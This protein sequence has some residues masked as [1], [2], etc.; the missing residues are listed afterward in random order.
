MTVAV[1]T[2]SSASSLATNPLRVH[3]VA[4]PAVG[5]AAA[6]LNPPFLATAF[7]NI[8]AGAAG[9]G[10]VERQGYLFAIYLP[11]ARVGAQ[12]PGVGEAAAGGTAAAGTALATWN[13]AD[14]ELYWCAYAWPVEAGKTGNRAFFINQEGDVASTSNLATAA[15]RY[16]GNA[17]AANIL[18]FGAAFSN[19]VAN[20]MDQ[21]I[22]FASMGF[23]SNDTNLWTQ[24]GN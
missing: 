24:V 7:G 9:P 10:V 20:S 17:A 8:A 22:G 21:P 3:T 6:L 23:T 19:T 13:T 16:T 2:A 14:C 4:N 1:S 11:A 12:I 5:A 18:A 15:V